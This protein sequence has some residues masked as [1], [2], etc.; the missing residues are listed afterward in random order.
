MEQVTGHWIDGYE[1][2]S[3]NGQWFEVLD[4]G[5]GSPVGKAAR[6][7]AEDVRAA[8]AAARKAL[9]APSW[10]GVDPAQR[11]RWLLRLGQLIERDRDRLAGLLA[12]ENGKPLGD[13]K[14]EISVAARYCE[15]FAGYADKLDGR[16]I[17]LPGGEFAVTRREPVGVVAHIIPWNYPVDILLR[18]AA[19]CLAAGNTVIAK[20]ARDTPLSS[21]EI[22][23][24][25]TEAG[26]PAGV[27]NVV[28]G[29]GSEAGD[30]LIH[31]R[32]LDGLVFCG[33]AEVGQDVLKAA[34]STLVPVLS[35]E[36]GGKAPCLVL[37]DGDALRAASGCANGIIHNSGQSC[38]CRSRLIVP[39]SQLAAVT[40]VV[41]EI[42]RQVALG[43][44]HSGARMGPLVNFRQREE[45]LAAI[46]RGKNE[47]ARLEF[48]GEVPVDASL[49]KG[50]FLTPAVFTGVETHMSLAQQEIFGPV[51]A[52]L[53][54][55]DGDEEAALALANDTVYGLSAELW[56]Q[57]PGKAI[58]FA[59]RL[60]SSHVTV[61]GSG[62]FG[63]EVPFGGIG[64]SGFGREGGIES[65][66]AYTRVKSLFLRTR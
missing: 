28:L 1:R 8:I 34:A 53:T 24:L 4:P 57:D 63:I 38:G 64:F 41:K 35:L 7:G 10:A 17:P 13:A 19:P 65:L 40:K 51:L 2:P 6:G 62:G 32:D 44:S 48:G 49:A 16:E 11:G 58:A 46:A 43:H 30:A 12:R 54:Y 31:S 26:F 55:P 59:R 47:G 37:S 18:G 21:L 61:N 14:G 3:A 60:N 39:A 23:R 25:A 52:I 27:F 42:F 29:Y 22:A 45:V 5:D 9:T 50:S 36:L 33:S 20:P 56:T 66:L 15:F